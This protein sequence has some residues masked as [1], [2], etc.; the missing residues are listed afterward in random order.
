VNDRFKL[1]MDVQ[2]RDVKVESAM[3]K[4]STPGV[5]HQSDAPRHKTARLEAHF[6]PS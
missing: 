4:G 1:R 5:C 3:V 6:S 2:P